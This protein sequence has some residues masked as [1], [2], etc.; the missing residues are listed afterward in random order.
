MG[1]RARAFTTDLRKGSRAIDK[2]D[3][4]IEYIVPAS[5]GDNP[6]VKFEDRLWVDV[7]DDIDESKSQFMDQAQYNTPMP[8]IGQKR[9]QD[10]DDNDKHSILSF[11]ETYKNNQCSNISEESVVSDIFKH[12][13]V[14]KY[15]KI[16]NIRDKYVLE[17]LYGNDG[18]S[19][20]WR[21]KVINLE[22]E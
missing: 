12:L 20:L 21:A 8:H 1:P 15:R 17:K 13:Y 9:F 18:Y 22:P 3:I 10:D 14:R 16:E 7:D 5:F 2:T 19:K 4:D 6:Y 11:C